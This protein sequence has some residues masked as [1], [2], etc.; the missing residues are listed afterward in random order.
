MEY[1]SKVPPFSIIGLQ[2][3]YD[4]LTILKKESVFTGWT[5]ANEN[6]INVGKKVKF[7]INKELNSP[8]MGFILLLAFDVEQ[9]NSLSDISWHFINKFIFFIVK[10]TRWTSTDK[11]V[12]ESSEENRS[13]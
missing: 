8:I 10:E 1:K 12:K 4:S 3:A 13:K 7:D 9:L 11:A 6:F 5:D 2:A